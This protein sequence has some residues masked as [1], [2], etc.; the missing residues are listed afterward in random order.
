MADIIVIGPRKAGKTTYLAALSYRFQSVRDQTLGIE[1]E[2]IGNHAE[3][4]K[5]DAQN[6]LYQGA[7]LDRTF[8]KNLEDIP[9]YKFNIN[10]PGNLLR[11]AQPRQIEINVKDYAG[12][13]FDDL[14][15]DP[16]PERLE[17]YLKSFADTT[18]WLLLLNDWEPFLNERERP[19]D[20]HC[21]KVVTVLLNKADKNAL[22]LAVVMSKCERG[23]LWPGR[24]EPERDIFAVRLP[25]TRAALKK[26]FKANPNHLEFFACSAFGVIA[27][28]QP[29]PNRRN[30][31]RNDYSMAVIKDR[32]DVW[33]PY[34]LIT[35]LVWLKTGRLW[36]WSH[37]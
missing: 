23:E 4:L 12:E 25:K 5:D 11:Q 6:I 32:D 34:G 22:R 24:Q 33:Q 7:R 17:E 1:V 35:P 14:D 13:I 3:S 2:A 27:P 31:I 19:T 16:V 18:R 8:P 10:I 15:E 20:E 29:L 36:K 26:F 28:S 9:N 30:V 21:E 37:I